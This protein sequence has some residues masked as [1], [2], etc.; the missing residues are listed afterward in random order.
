VRAAPGA[1]QISIDLEKGGI[2]L[3][4]IADN[5]SGMSREDA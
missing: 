3:I 2:D 5:G 4:V 1:D